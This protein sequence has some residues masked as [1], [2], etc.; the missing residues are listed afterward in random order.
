MHSARVQLHRGEE[1]DRLQ[2]CNDSESDCLLARSMR[3][4]PSGKRFARRLSTVT[5]REVTVGVAH[6]TVSVEH[7]EEQRNRR[8]AEGGDR[9]TWSALSASTLIG[10]KP[11]GLVCPQCLLAAR[12]RRV[13]R[14][15]TRVVL[16]SWSGAEAVLALLARRLLAQ[17]GAQKMLRRLL[18]RVARTPVPFPAA[19]SADPAAVPLTHADAATLSDLLESAQGRSR[20]ASRAPL[21]TLATALFLP[22]ALLA[23]S[24]WALIWS[25]PPLGDQPHWTDYQKQWTYRNSSNVNVFERFE[26]RAMDGTATASFIRT[27]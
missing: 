15:E 8:D 21:R 11:E 10:S 23:L 27:S 6:E 26:I 9:T 19:V 5:Q 3:T 22:G 20:H 7:E 12:E 18:N 17:S 25:L 4:V 2:A 24:C 13:R 14:R 1:P 16:I